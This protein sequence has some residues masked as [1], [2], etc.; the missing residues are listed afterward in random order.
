MNIIKCSLCQGEIVGPNGSDAGAL[1]SFKVLGRWIHAPVCGEC[2][3]NQLIDDIELRLV[4]NRNHVEGKEMKD[5]CYFC[6]CGGPLVKITCARS[7]TAE[8]LDSACVCPECFNK[9][10]DLKELFCIGVINADPDSGV[11]GV[12]G[13]SPE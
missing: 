4:D 7:D 12:A 2:C 1:P 10:V 3:S 6:D 5:K 9:C 11:S 8:V 13:H